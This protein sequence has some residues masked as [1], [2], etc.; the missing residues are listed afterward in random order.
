MFGFETTIKGRL[1]RACIRCAS[2]TGSKSRVK[3]ADEKRAS[4]DNGGRPF[5]HYGLVS[6]DKNR[7]RTHFTRS[8]KL[9]LCK[10]LLASLARSSSAIVIELGG[11]DHL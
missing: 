7:Q 4:L 2:R 3:L 6:V 1:R 8:A 5:L 9:N 10:G 11:C